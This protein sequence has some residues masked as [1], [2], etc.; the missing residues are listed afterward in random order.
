MILHN[1]C[2]VKK[3]IKYT[4]S[5]RTSLSVQILSKSLPNLLC[6]TIEDGTICMWCSSQEVLPS[7]VEKQELTVN[8]KEGSENRAP[9]NT[10]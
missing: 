3:G 2:V 1:C 7:S 10:F 8:V 4:D 9:F 6:Q 5:R